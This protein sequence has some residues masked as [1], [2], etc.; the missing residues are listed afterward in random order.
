[1]GVFLQSL[2][3]CV[4]LPGEMGWVFSF[5]PSIPVCYC[6]ESWNG[7]F[8]SA[9]PR[10]SHW[11]F[12]KHTRLQAELHWARQPR[13]SGWTQDTVIVIKAVL[14]VWPSLTA[15]TGG[16]GGEDAGK[17]ARYMGLERNQCPAVSSCF[18][19][20]LEGRDRTKAE[21]M[22][23]KKTERSQRKGA[24]HSLAAS[25]EL[26]GG[27]AGHGVRLAQ[28]LPSPSSLTASLEDLS[29]KA[30]SVFR[31]LALDEDRDGCF[32]ELLAASCEV[33]FLPFLSI[34][35]FL[36]H[37]WKIDPGSRAG[38][39]SAH[40]TYSSA[41]LCSSALVA[42]VEMLAKNSR[43]S[44]EICFPDFAKTFVLINQPKE[45]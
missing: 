27:H 25:R 31:L 14:P 16:S 32:G 26:K 43:K 41:F 17:A 29:P 6:Q 13:H 28:T 7:Y 11:A 20:A 30:A 2:C 23:P 1:M 8:P 24:C 15:E 42:P 40:S 34:F 22:E 36:E 35:L 39:S 3:P 18:L 21:L 10:L 33:H 44:P 45:M 9:R 19:G 5:S 12:C 38:R 4:L 37:Q